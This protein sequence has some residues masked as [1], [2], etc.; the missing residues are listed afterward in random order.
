MYDLRQVMTDSESVC[1]YERSAALAVW[2][3]NIEFA[4]DALERGS[5]FHAT[6]GTITAADR[7][8]YHARMR[9]PWSPPTPIA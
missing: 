3:G 4:V 7:D 9:A 6:Y 5:A 2:H 1:E 8:T